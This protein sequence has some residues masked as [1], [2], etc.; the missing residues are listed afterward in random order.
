MTSPLLLLGRRLVIAAALIAIAGRPASAKVVQVAATRDTVLPFIG[1]RGDLPK[2][3]ARIA[4]VFDSGFAA[5]ERE[6]VLRELDAIRPAR[7]LGR[8]D[9]PPY[10]SYAFQVRLRGHERPLSLYMYWSS[11]RAVAVHIRPT[12]TLVLDAVDSAFRAARAALLLPPGRVRLRVADPLVWTGTDPV[13]S[14]GVGSDEA[15]HCEG[16]GLESHSESRGDTL[17]IHVDGVPSKDNCP[18]YNYRPVQMP[19][20]HAVVPGRSLVTVD[21]RGDTNLFAVQVTDTSLALST[22]RS[23]FVTADERLRWRVPSGSFIISCE[24]F[25]PE[26][27][28]ACDKLLALVGRRAGVQRI[29]F[30]TS[31]V[32]PLREGALAYR[33]A[34]DQVMASVRSCV[35]TIAPTFGRNATVELRIRLRP[36][37]WVV[38]G[39]Y[40]YGPNA[41]RREASDSTCVLPSSIAERPKTLTAYAYPLNCPTPTASVRRVVASVLQGS[42]GTPEWFREHGLAVPSVDDLKPLSGPGDVPRCRAI[43]STGSRHPVFVFR[44]GRYYVATTVDASGTDIVLDDSPPLYLVWLL[45]SANTVV[46]VPGY[47]SLGQLTFGGSPKASAGPRPAV[48]PWGDT[49]PVP[50]RYTPHDV[51]VTSTRGG[52][53][54]LQWTKPPRWPVDLALERAVGA[55]AFTSIPAPIYASAVATM[56]TTALPSAAYRYRLRA[57]LTS[58]DSAFSNEVSVTTPR[59]PT[60]RLAWPRGLYLRPAVHGQV[61]DSLTGKP[62]A[63]LYLRVKD[64]SIFFSTDS[65]GRYL[66]ADVPPGTH[67]VIF[68]CPAKRG[69]GQRTV[70]TR[71]LDVTPRTDSVV[72]FYIRLRTCEEP[73]LRTWSGEFRGHYV[74]GFETSLFAPCVPFESFVGTAYEGVEEIFAWVGFSEAASAQA[75]SMWPR[76][77]TRAQESPPMYVRWRATV[78]GPSSYGHGGFPLY[79]MSVTEVMELRH[80]APSDC[81]Q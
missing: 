65:L 78:T 14:A 69:W 4:A 73:P 71:R 81:R 22:I 24:G 66:F 51:H 8:Y 68:S 49:V 34:N 13:M 35:A 21:Y 44:A 7:E 76:D 12:D 57:R 5:P 59:V 62:V 50:V 80:A 36:G 45:D 41:V 52:D 67:K 77:T 31:G 38:D 63:G 23:S 2:M 17:A 28:A 25:D 20:W 32:S 60:P 10:R 26:R 18:T 56:D 37:P 74:G 1:L 11:P 75:R 61:L 16:F 27:R 6:L 42:E 58:G 39:Y 64:K 15:K 33:Y 30:D 3:L 72:D 40:G 47:S 43:D 70:A 79:E 9:R 55:G 46:H 54:V 48:Q 29:I 53:V 19:H